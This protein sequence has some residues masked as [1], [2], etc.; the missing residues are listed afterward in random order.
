MNVDSAEFEFL[1]ESA[2]PDWVMRI[3]IRGEG[4][5]E[6]AI[7][8]VAEVGTVPVEALM[9]TYEPGGLRGFLS[10]E[11]AE[12]DEL[13]IGLLDEPLEGTDISYT[14]PNGGVA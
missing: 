14:R 2:H 7:P 9:P 8:I 3:T 10:A 11:P 12:G 6:G 4:F 13:R 1:A 5:E